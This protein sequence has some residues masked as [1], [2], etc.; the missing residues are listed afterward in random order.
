MENTVVEICTLL[1]IIIGR[2]FK[3]WESTYF[4]QM[5]EPSQEDC[6]YVEFE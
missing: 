2:G 1:N 3:L 6:K 4:N 5:N